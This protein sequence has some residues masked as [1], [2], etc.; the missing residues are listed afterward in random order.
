MQPQYLPRS[1]LISGIIL[2]PSV[3]DSWHK[4]KKCASHAVMKK[5]NSKLHSVHVKYLLQPFF[6]EPTHYSSHLSLSV[7]W[8]QLKSA[9][10][11]PAFK[12]ELNRSCVSLVSTFNSRAFLSCS[13]ICSATGEFCQSSCASHSLAHQAQLNS[14]QRIDRRSCSMLGPT[15]ALQALLMRIVQAGRSAFEP[16]HSRSIRACASFQIW[17]EGPIAATEPSLTCNFACICMVPSLRHPQAPSIRAGTKPLVQE[18]NLTC[19][20]LAD[21]GLLIV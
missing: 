9:A 13:P 17:L 1:R 10:D 2:M 16:K 19:F 4:V 12:S 20:L 6:P 14:G 11:P 7:S 5:D 3:G 8:R 15:P 21:E 18:L